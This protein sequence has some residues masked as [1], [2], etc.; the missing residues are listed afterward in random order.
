M[1]AAVSYGRRAALCAWIA[2]LMMFAKAARA[3]T[4]AETT[5]FSTAAE[6]AYSTL[7]VTGGN[8]DLWP[9]CWADD[10]NLYT[11]SGDGNGFGG[12]GS[13]MLV[14]KI[15]GMPP[16]LSGKT[17][18]KNIGT[19][20]MGSG[21]DRKPT[22]MLCVN[23]TIYLAFQNLDS[24]SF[25]SAPAASIA[26][27]TDHGLS[28]TW[29]A[30]APMFGGSGR[31]PLFTTVFFLD[32]GMNSANAIDGYVYAYGLDN[33]WRSQQAM[34]LGRVPSGSVQTRSTWQFY[35]GTD[36]NGNPVWTSTISQKQPVLV[37]TRLLYPVMFGTDCP[38][39][40]AVIAQ[41]GVVYDKPLARYIFSSWS[42]STH[43][44]YEAPQ[45]WGPW[46]HVLSNDFGPLR[47][48]Y[49]RGQYGTSIPSKFISSDGKTL[50]LQSNV[51]CSGNSYTYSLRNVYLQVPLGSYATNSESNGNLALAPGTKAIS[52]STHYGSLCGAKCSDQ[53]NGG[54]LNVSEDDYDEEQKAADWWGYR[55]PLPYTF[56]EVVYQTGGM[57]SNGG[58]FASNLQVQVQQNGQWTAVPQNVIVTPA[59]PY[60]SAAQAQAT[61]TFDFPP[62]SGTGVRIIGVP[63]GTAY[64]TSIGQLAV[65]YGGRD[66]VVN[67]GFESQG[68]SAVLSPWMAEGPDTH[69]IE[70]GQGTEHTGANDGLIES[71]SSSWNGLTQTIA[72]TPNTAYT[73]TGWVENDFGKNTGSFGVRGAS[74]AVIAQTSIG[75]A[76][77]YTPLTVR[78]N[79]GSNSSV[80]IF[81]GFTGQKKM[82]LMRLD[83][84]SLR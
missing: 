55:W 83:D 81:A 47:T 67:G 11:A 37:D 52:K 53:L 72:V 23:S 63:G 36:A 42:C 20:W 80:T 22:G 8:G 28:W 69:S 15:S 38:A 41:G 71:S 74:G 34:Y 45:P 61:Y 39:Q 9:S 10:D 19:N 60:S 2:V 16:S 78:F 58:W 68:T 25:N 46:S 29:D 14:S 65:Y 32:F 44:I 76:S 70:V 73:L 35:A 40:D 59:Y 48:L 30:S 50:M 26:K 51:C 84:V 31:A 79:S 21:F 43:E 5:F 57:F 17:L 49:N 82:L 27:S 66:L 1:K 4:P 64:F 6:E 75:A 13:D 24:N 62:V 56:D 18:A 12:S 77:S 54:P 3:Q 7:Q 33:N